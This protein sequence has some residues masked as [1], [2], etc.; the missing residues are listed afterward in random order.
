MKKIM[1]G[2]GEGRG[3]HGPWRRCGQTQQIWVTTETGSGAA[4]GGGA[5][6]SGDVPEDEEGLRRHSIGI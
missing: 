1:E 5:G 2:E 4:S 6:G 3:K